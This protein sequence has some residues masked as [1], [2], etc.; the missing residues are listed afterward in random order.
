M[1]VGEGSEAKASVWLGRNEISRGARGFSCDTLGSNLA[2]SREN[3][4]T[5]R[6]SG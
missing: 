3:N 4:S 1:R 6:V 5:R 2:P